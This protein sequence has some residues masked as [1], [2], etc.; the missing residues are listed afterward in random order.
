MPEEITPEGTESPETPGGPL[1]GVRILDFTRA[2]AGPFGTMILGDLG[3]D[4]VKIEPPGGDD[5]RGWS[6]PEVN[7]ISSYFLSANRNK[8]SIC[9]DLKRMESGE[10]IR[11]LV[12]NTDVIVENFRPGTADKLGIG[13]GEVTR[14]NK[15]LIYC[16][17]SGYG[18]TGP[19][20]EKPGFD[21]TILA[22]S[23]LMSVTG[24]PGRPPVKFG[25]PI[26]DISAGMFA[27]I[28]ILSA[29]Y[30]RSNSGEGQ[31]IDMSMMD[32]SMLLLTHQA[33]GYFATGQDPQPMGS[34]H[35]SIAPYQ[36]YR[37]NDGYVSVA[38][39]SEKLWK[40]FCLALGL[41]ELIEDSRF[42]NN[43]DRVENRDSLNEIIGEFL[44]GKSREW[45]VDT[46]ENAGVP[47]SPINRISD[48]ESDAQVQ[49]RGMIAEMEHPEYG[50]FRTPGNIFR[51]SATPGV[52]KRAPPVLGEHTEEVL[53]EAGIGEDKIRAL[54][55]EGV[56]R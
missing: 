43:S 55:V 11:R 44:A 37:T 41:E 27:A 6:P 54:L 28:S 19:Y 9:I 29:L 45:T 25:V 18:Q 51:M 39:G 26:T 52:L 17:I 23:G 5:T 13:Y 8:R 7:G 20:R 12:E 36:V 30:H 53:R 3:A 47:V 48:L 42:S 34:A 31:Y 4:V 14:Y 50:G 38:V 33:S 10:I 15:S 22:R 56:I 21:L 35:A 2:M 40:A 1:K 46:L 49:E 32:S 24:E 16:S